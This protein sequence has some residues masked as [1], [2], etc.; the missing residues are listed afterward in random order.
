MKFH[1]VA[2]SFFCP[3]I[4]HGWLKNLPRLVEKSPTAGVRNSPTA[5]GTFCKGQRKIHQGWQ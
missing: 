1:F 2:K 3:K 4:H 5:G